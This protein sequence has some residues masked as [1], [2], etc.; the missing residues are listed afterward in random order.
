MAI[1]FKN[2]ISIINNLLSIVKKTK[3][4]T[5]RV[6][7]TTLILAINR[8]GTSKERVKRDMLT[9]LANSP[10]P[11]TLSDGTPAPIQNLVDIF[12]ESVFN[13]LYENARIDIVIPPNGISITGQ[14]TPTGQVYGTNIIPSQNAVGVIV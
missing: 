6:P 9:K 3:I 1:N 13:E 2:P 8:S 12:V 14:A 10:I 4:K 11:I 5:P 7:A